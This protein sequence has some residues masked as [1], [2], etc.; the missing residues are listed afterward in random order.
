MVENKCMTLVYLSLG[1]NKGDR[2]GYIQQATSI[3]DGMDDISLVRTSA[4]YESEPWGTNTKNWFVNAMIEISTTQ[5]PQQ[6]LQTVQSVEKRLGRNREIEG[7]YGDRTLDIDI[8]FYGNEIINDENL[9]IPHKLFHQRAFTIVPML[10]LAPDFVHP[11]LKKTVMQ[12]HDELEDPE[13]VFL[14]GTRVEL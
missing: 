1:S 9:V 10:E 5:T 12:L 13:M 4:F 11:T 8:I 6:L 2:V 14:Y 7:H 3:L